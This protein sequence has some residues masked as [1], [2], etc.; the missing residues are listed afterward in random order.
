MSVPTTSSAAVP[1]G[2]RSS[3]SASTA[4]AALPFTPIIFCGPGSNLY[5]LCDPQAR[6]SASPEASVNDAGDSAAA[7][8]SS[9]AAVSGAN[10]PSTG[11]NAGGAGAG[12]GRSGIKA[13]L[14]I[15]NRPAI[16]FPLQLLFSSGFNYAVVFA[17]KEAH[18]AIA[19][20]LKSCYLQPPSSSSAGATGAAP[21]T[22]NIVVREW[23]PNS[24]AAFSNSAPE[25]TE[26]H[27]TFHV[28]LFPLGPYD[29]KAGNGKAARPNKLQAQK[30]AG[31]QGDDAEKGIHFSKRLGA[32]TAQLLLWLHQLGRLQVS[33]HDL[34]ARSC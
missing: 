6:F 34:R 30:N 14:P 20:A 9:S 1:S 24:P 8:G 17:A 12:A 29:G 33:L 25:N 15:G 22:S 5:P 28:E 31:P 21:S 19:S 10:A 18:P 26:G 32:G 27:N 11:P 4:A 23:N 2:N 16:S 13:L 3:T 7:Q